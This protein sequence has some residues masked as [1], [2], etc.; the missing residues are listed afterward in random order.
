M[1][2]RYDN[3]KLVWLKQSGGKT[4]NITWVSPDEGL[5]GSFSGG[6]KTAI[7][8]KVRVING[9]APVFTLAAG[10]LPPGLTFD[11][12]TGAISGIPENINGTYD[13]TL[14]AASG[15]ANVERAFQIAVAVNLPPVWMTSTGT[16]GSP[17]DSTD[18][19]FNLEAVDPE[20]QPVTYSLVTGS[21]PGGL[22][23]DPNTGKIDGRLRYVNANTTFYFTVKASDG[24]ASTNESFN[25]TVKANEGPVWQTSSQGALGTFVE[26]YFVSYQLAATDAENNTLTYSI[27]SGDLPVGLTM[28]SAGLITGTVGE[29]EKE[30]MVSFTVRVTDGVKAA[31]RSFAMKVMPNLPPVWNT[32][33]PA[34]VETAGY[35]VTCPMIASDPNG[36]PLTFSLKD[37]SMLPND[38]AIV[39]SD[40]I[41]MVPDVLEDT[42]FTFT[43]VASDGVLSSEFEVVVTAK[44]NIDP[45]WVTEADLGKVLDTTE[46]RIQL[47]ATDPNGKS[48]AYAA[49]SDLPA[50]LSLSSTGLLTGNV[51]DLDQDTSFEFSVVATDGIN[52]I[53]RDFTLLVEKDVAPVWTTSAGSLGEAHADRDFS[54]DLAATEPNGQSLYYSLKTPNTLPPGL[55]LSG[56]RIAGKAGTLRTEDKLYTFTV[57]VADGTGPNAKTVERTFAIMHK[58]NLPPVWNQVSEA[59]LTEAFEDMPFTVSVSAIDPEGRPVKYGTPP[60]GYL[61]QGW[62]ITPAGVLSGKMPKVEQ[63]TPF[64]FSLMASCDGDDSQRNSAV[65]VFRVLSKFN[66]APVFTSPTSIHTVESRTTDAAITAVNMGNGP[67]VY[68]VVSGALPT[69]LTLN[70]NGTISGTSPIVS[71]NTDFTATIRAHNGIKF[72]EQTVVFTVEHNLAPVWQTEIGS[73]GVVPSGKPRSFVVSATDGN[74]QPVTYS[75]VSGTLPVG[76]TLNPKTGAITGT[77]AIAADDLTSTF[78]IGASDGVVRTDREFS[79]TVS[80]NTAPT[81][82]TPSGSLGDVTRNKNLILNVRAEDVEG[83]VLTYS[84]VAGALPQGIL[85]DAQTGAIVGHAPDVKV[86][87]TYTFTVRASDGALFTDREFSLSVKIDAVPVWQTPAGSLGAVLSGYPATF[88]VVA[89]D[90]EGLS[91]AYSLVS[92]TLPPTWSFASGAIKSQQTTPVSSTDETYTFVIRADDGQVFSDRQF[93]IT[94]LKNTKPTWNV[95][96]NTNLGSRKERTDLNFT[97]QATDPEGSHSS[98]PAIRYQIT[99][100]ALPSGITLNQS[101][102]AVSGKLP[103]VPNDTPMNFGISAFDGKLYSDELKYTGTILFDSPPIWVTPSGLLGRGLEDTKVSFTVAASSNGDQVTYGVKT[104]NTLPGTLTLDPI[105]GVISG[106]LPLVNNDTNMSFTLTVTSPQEKTSERQ[107]SITVDNNLAPVWQ[108]PAGMLVTDLAGTPFSFVLTATDPN[109]TVVVYEI[110][111]GNLPE[112][113]TFDAATRT[114]SGTLPMVENDT[115]YTFTVGASDGFIRVDRT[116]SFRSQKDTAPVW[117]TAADLGSALEEDD[118]SVT[119]VAVDAQSKPVTYALKAGSSL[120]GT[121]VLQGT[122][123]VGQATIPA[124]RISGKLPVTPEAQTYSFTVIASDGTMTVE[125]EFTLTVNPNAA[126]VWTTP[127][128]LGSTIEGQPYTFTLQATDPENKGVRYSQVSGTLPLGLTITNGGVISGTPNPV[129]QDTLSTFTIRASDG[130]KHKDQTFTLLVTNAVATPDNFS[131]KIVLNL[132]MNNAVGQPFEDVTGKSV[133]ASTPLSFSP[134]EYSSVAMMLRGSLVNEATGRTLEG[135]GVLEGAP[136]Q[137]GYGALDFTNGGA[138]DGKNSYV[139]YDTNVGLVGGAMERYPNEYDTYLGIGMTFEM[140][141]KIEDRDGDTQTLFQ[142]GQGNGTS[143]GG[144]LAIQHRPGVGLVVVEANSAAWNAPKITRP[145]NIADGQWHHIALNRTRTDGSL[146]LFVDGVQ[147]LQS[148]SSTQNYGMTEG[149]CYLGNSADNN[150]GING[151]IDGFKIIRDLDLYVANFT[152]SST[153]SQVMTT[154]SGSGVALPTTTETNAKTDFGRALDVTNTGTV[155]VSAHRD[156]D[157]GADDVTIDFWVYPQ[158]T[159]G[160][161]MTM[162][163]KVNGATIFKFAQIGAN[164]F[165]VVSSTFGTI[166]VTPDWTLNSWNHIALVLGTSGGQRPLSLYVNGV[167]KFTQAYSGTTTFSSYKTFVSNLVI[168]R[169][170]NGQNMWQGMIDEVRITRAARYSGTSFSPEVVEPLQLPQITT[171]SIPAGIEETPFETTIVAVDKANSG[172]V[173]Y[174]ASGLPSGWSIS[175]TTGVITGFYPTASLTGRSITVTATDSKGAKAGRTFEIVSNKVSTPSALKYS[176]RFN[177]PTGAGT[178]STTT[179]NVS[180]A[181]VLPVTVQNVT[182]AAAPSKP[183]E[184]AL[185]IK[186]GYVYRGNYNNT[187]S[188]QFGFMKTDTFTVEGWF[189]MTG[190]ASSSSVLFDLGGQSIA[191]G[192]LSTNRLF[193]GIAGQG[194][195]SVGNALGL[196][197][198]HHVAVTRTGR[199]YKTFIDGALVE[200][201]T[202]DANA[203]N[204]SVNNMSFGTIAGSASSSYLWPNDTYIRNWNIYNTAKYDT[205]FVPVWDNYNDPIWSGNDVLTWGSEGDDVNVQITAEKAGSRS[206]SYSSLDLPAGLTLSATGLLTGVYPAASTSFNVVATDTKGA[207][208]KSLRMTLPVGEEFVGDINAYKTVQFYSFTGTEGAK[209]VD[210]KGGSVAQFA[211]PPTISLSQTK[212]LGGSLKLVGGATANHLKAAPV[213]IPANTDFTME[214]WFYRT[215]TTSNGVLWAMN[216]TNATA[217]A[218]RCLYIQTDGRFVFQNDAGINGAVTTTTNSWNHVALVRESGVISLYVNGTKDGSVAFEG[219]LTCDNH[220]SI[221][222]YTTSDF[223]SSQA[224]FVGNVN[225]YRLTV[226]LARYSGDTVA[227]PRGPLGASLPNGIVPPIYGWSFNKPVGS[228]DFTLDAGSAVSYT[229]TGSVTFMTDGPTNVIRFTEGSK[230]TVQQTT[231]L[232]SLLSGDYTF[233]SWINIDPTSF[234]STLID[235]GAGKFQIRQIYASLRVRINGSGDAYPGSLGSWNKWAHIAIVKSGATFRFFLNGVDSGLTNTY[236]Q[237][238]S[239]FDN[240]PVII[241]GKSGGGTSAGAKFSN[242]GFFKG[243]K[244]TG[245]FTPPPRV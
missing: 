43:V 73:L 48:V 12:A 124:G 76:L 187:A 238:T 51:I 23:L 176:W 59:I 205:A 167:R 170:T 58:V 197:A 101:T 60:G 210:A 70:K 164:S 181:D 135:F 245:S 87:T 120:P 177:N 90:P 29:V 211:S 46:V 53:E 26:D 185:N 39:G 230:L 175:P 143:T 92:G 56:S 8:V 99:S 91:V 147:H 182:F 127:S 78:V 106:T 142:H 57:V 71:E 195:H 20:G 194:S 28:N 19:S 190:N 81:W 118:F 113:V 114:L 82:I 65:R 172:T 47:T 237:N 123:S 192:V 83:S 98:A 115:T 13:F 219:A 233:E 69:G 40:V 117:A 138:T 153:L 222:G 180:A 4:T 77:P 183:N 95:V 122:T 103:F 139:I 169:D 62:S 97:V 128:N 218:A 49:T 151:L 44:A 206:L 179:A 133:I 161:I 22:K 215:S 209:P 157:F 14:R 16:L 154:R 224:Q 141:V 207:S 79:I 37:G 146:R 236:A 165:Q 55:N 5:I 33:T 64:S 68:T 94:M 34:A 213:A 66:R 74:N 144:K 1:G 89:T 96:Y 88:N 80:G 107:F 85:L 204:L 3:M 217:A 9:P 102:G 110:V 93:S 232:G 17:F 50:G 11:A 198:W 184:T 201:F 15:E 31:D 216:N 231:Q 168:G 72:T 61:P 171:T 214:L 42:D 105:T 149:N 174:N 199:V 130:L 126:P 145:G 84:V 234:E 27:V 212:W 7:P 38:W 132:K 112:G 150:T 35:V 241:N 239:Y 243:I 186:N 229:P 54:Y 129:S 235:I 134:N 67:M 25:I 178:P 155:V 18:Y 125:R 75:M 193:L 223:G 158:A 140:W 191:I 226:G 148:A 121:L 131:D 240:A 104:G 227:V 2:V 208:T 159:N 203:D 36:K 196:N 202:A 228:T 189:Y 86:D 109:N 30:T 173:T 152:P 220:I 45:V 10:Q 244:Y 136:S 111:D 163:R 119:L 6:Q 116:F 200:T 52:E 188:G 137:S 63:D 156:F 166:S 225:D 160:T 24:I 21:L 221:G 242:L 100:G 41:G 162:A 32:P 108:T